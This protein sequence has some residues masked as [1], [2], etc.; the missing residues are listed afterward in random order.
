[1]DGL[2]VPRLHVT[3]DISVDNQAY[4][5]QHYARCQLA[6]V[7]YEWNA[8]EDKVSTTAQ[9]L[10]G[11]RERVRQ[12]WPGLDLWLFVATGWL[13][14]N[15]VSRYKRIWMRLAADGTCLASAEPAKDA[16]VAGIK[17]I[18]HV[19]M[20][21]CTGSDAG[22]I[23]SLLRSPWQTQL[24]LAE[25]AD[26]EAVAARLLSSDW[27]QQPNR[28]GPLVGAAASDLPVLAC[29]PFGWFDDRASGAVILARP[30][31]L[32]RLYPEFAELSLK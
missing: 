9:A 22:E 4:V 28:L 5:D 12:H 31:L 7:S 21:R 20:M 2:R 25:P 30:G 6:A 29:L 27:L 8:W 18:Q 15:R 13:E 23:A 11:L 3:P 32:A 10:D 17:G 19:G 24:I 16:I 26:A 1:M 14:D